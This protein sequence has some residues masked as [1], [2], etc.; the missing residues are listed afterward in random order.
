MGCRSCRARVW[1]MRWAE[2]G[3]RDQGR[4][5]HSSKVANEPPSKNQP[6]FFSFFLFGF[7]HRGL[8]SHKWIE[9]KWVWQA[10][11]CETRTEIAI[12]K[13]ERGEL[14]GRRTGWTGSGSSIAIAKGQVWT[15]CTRHCAVCVVEAMWR[16]VAIRA[17]LSKRKEKSSV[18]VLGRSS[19]EALGLRFWRLTPFD[20]QYNAVNL[21]LRTGVTPWASAVEDDLEFA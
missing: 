1:C 18:R 9:S 4:T 21:R 13:S 6:A 10:F 2:K 5:Q 11:F 17:Q 19:V 14:Q 16:S 8:F 3:K 20:G 15:W 7:S 12:V